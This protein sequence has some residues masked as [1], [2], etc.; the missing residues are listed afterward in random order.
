M[1]NG[2]VIKGKR[3][4]NIP[5]CTRM[6]YNLKLFDDKVISTLLYGREM[7][8]YNRIEIS[9]LTSLEFFI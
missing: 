2:I 7:K 5:E 6:A 1:A 4:F 9:I 3:T 8:E